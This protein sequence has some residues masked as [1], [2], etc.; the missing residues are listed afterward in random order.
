[1]NRLSRDERD[2]SCPNCGSENHSEL[3]YSDTIEYRDLVINLQDLIV[4]CCESCGTRWF[5]GA[6]KEH[7][8]GLLKAG[9]ARERDRL[10]QSLGLL[11]GQQIAQ[12]RKTF[13]LSQKE[14]SML[15]G[16]GPKSFH[17]YESGEVLQSQAM[18]KLLKVVNAFGEKA[19]YFLKHDHMPPV[20]YRMGHAG[21]GFIAAALEVHSPSSRWDFI[22]KRVGTAAADSVDV[23]LV[24]VQERKQISEEMRV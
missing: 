5:T 22:E 1:M 14:A 7:N 19:L 20:V 24:P 18:D 16:G 6:Q 3:R 9:Y 8:D 12:I 15:F 10:R 2:Q 17:K 11:N 21:Q 4:T 13:G 23:F